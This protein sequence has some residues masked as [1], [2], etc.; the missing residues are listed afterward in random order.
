MTC[1]QPTQC[2]QGHGSLQ[3]E[4]FQGKA[5]FAILSF[6]AST[7]MG[8]FQVKSCS[9]SLAPG[10]KMAWNRAVAQSTTDRQQGKKW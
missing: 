4:A 7:T 5:C 10:V 6:P 9:I 8:N 2:G 3:A 1:F